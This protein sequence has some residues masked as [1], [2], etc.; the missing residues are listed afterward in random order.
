MRILLLV[1]TLFVGL[2]S[3]RAAEAIDSAVQQGLDTFLS[4]G[5]ESGVHAWYPDRPELAAE[6]SAKIAAA[7]QK[8]G[9]II[10]SEVVQIQPV[11]KRVRRYYVA[12][13]FTRSPLWIRIER[14]QSQDKAFFLPLKLST[15]PDDILPAYVTEFL[16]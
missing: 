10:D 8:L 12:L 4:N 13:Y 16:R 7:T 9:V 11:S 6:L 1:V 3:A 5:I 2:I 15:N 14:Y